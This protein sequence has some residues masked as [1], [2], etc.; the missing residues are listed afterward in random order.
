M[1]FDDKFPTA[2]GK[3]RF[4]PADLIPANE[5]PDS[6]YPMV[7]I[8][9][10]QL[11]HWHTG[12]MTRRSAVLDEL[13]PEAMAFLAPRDVEKLGIGRG[14]MIR[15]STRRGAIE[16]KVRVENLFDDQYQTEFGYG[17]ADRAAYAGIRYRF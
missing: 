5:R 4:V 9:G 3:A 13:E 17:A 2:T 14:D 16:L 12:A 7:L 1:V 11:E 8:T 10:R 15:V 6:E